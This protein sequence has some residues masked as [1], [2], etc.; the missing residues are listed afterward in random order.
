MDS[1][2]LDAEINLAIDQGASAVNIQTVNELD[3]KEGLFR[4]DFSVVVASIGSIEAANE[5]QLQR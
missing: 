3:D 1:I 4:K 5:H 2:D